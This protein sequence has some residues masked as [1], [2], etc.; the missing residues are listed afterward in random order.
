VLHANLRYLTCTLFFKNGGYAWSGGKIGKRW[1]A[2]MILILHSLVIDAFAP[3]QYRNRVVGRSGAG[4]Q[5]MSS[6]DGSE[7]E[8]VKGSFS[9]HRA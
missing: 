1:L 5:R 8:W 6:G 2:T 3:S 9:F 4:N 7:D